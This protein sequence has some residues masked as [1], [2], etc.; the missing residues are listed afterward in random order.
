MEGTQA[1]RAFITGMPRSGTTLLDKLLT[2][3]GTSHLY[4]QPLPL[5]FSR[6]KSLFLDQI[7]L[8]SRYPLNDMLLSNHYDPKQWVTF[9]HSFHI[10]RSFYQSVVDSMRSFSGQYTPSIEPE[11]LLQPGESLSLTAFINAYLLKLGGN[12]PRQLLGLKETWCEEYLPYL[13]DNGFKCIIIIRDPRD[14]VCSLNSGKGSE[15]GG[16]VRPL[17]YNIRTWRK[18]VAFSHLLEDNPNFM[19]VRYEDLVRDPVQNLDRIFSFLKIES[20]DTSSLHE[21]LKDQDGKRWSSNSSHNS[22]DSVSDAS[23]G[24]HKELLTEQ[25]ISFIEACCFPEMKSLGYHSD[26]KLEDLSNIL[27]SFAD[28]YG[29]ERPELEKFAWSAARCG[30]EL[31]RLALLREKT[32]RSSYFLFESAFNRLVSAQDYVIKCEP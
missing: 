28:D 17:L 30:E 6:I 1:G 18:S 9:L 31:E 4:S 19:A 24:Q 12:K 29:Q 7:G 13:V 14:V 16:R 25:R 22:Y 10:D 32:Y 15:Y 5:L 2:V 27:N 23:I 21:N 3:Q 20:I 11:L 8:D 26:L